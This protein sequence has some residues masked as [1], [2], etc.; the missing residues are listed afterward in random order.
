MLLYVILKGTMFPRGAVWQSLFWVAVGFMVVGVII[1]TIVFAACA[2]CK[3]NKPMI[4]YIAASTLADLSFGTISFSY[5]SW[6]YI[7]G[8]RR[9]TTWECFTESIAIR[10]LFRQKLTI[11]FIMFLDRHLAIFHPY[12][13]VRSMASRRGALTCLL[14]ACGVA[15]MFTLAIG[16]CLQFLVFC[17]PSMEFEENACTPDM[18]LGI[19][20]GGTI[21]PSVY[22]FLYTVQEYFCVIFMALYSSIKIILLSFFGCRSMSQQ[23]VLRSG[24]T[25]LQKNHYCLDIIGRKEM[26]VLVLHG[27]EMLRILL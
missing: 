4:I 19:A 11:T 2:I 13:Y 25:G 9:L 26:V 14:I 7:V 1:S 15:L 12:L 20:C 6:T 3:F 8:V 21:V 5:I 27:S 18:L 10:L 16:I 22:L 17:R 24:N 23:E